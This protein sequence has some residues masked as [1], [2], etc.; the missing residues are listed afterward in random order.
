M[1]SAGI[2]TCKD[3]D[4]D[5]SDDIDLEYDE[6]ALL[7][8]KRRR[9]GSGS[10]SSTFTSTSSSSLAE[11]NA[12]SQFPS[13]CPCN[14]GDS[15]AENPKA[16]T[17]LH[18]Q[19][20]VPAMKIPVWDSQAFSDKP[21]VR[22]HSVCHIYGSEVPVAP[23]FGEMN[24]IVAFPAAVDWDKHKKWMCKNDSY[25]YRTS[26]YHQSTRSISFLDSLR[27]AKAA[28]SCATSHC[29]DTQNPCIL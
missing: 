23:V 2:L 22:P 4:M 26:K 29:S 1:E 11:S 18:F 14:S 10:L 19:C 12:K 25:E 9:K 6:L 5:Q 3:V 21:H 7:S 16:M 24:P 8:S 13:V 27:A 20:L 28:N 17:T 15:K